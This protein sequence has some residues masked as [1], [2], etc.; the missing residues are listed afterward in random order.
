M[1]TK[2]ESFEIQEYGDQNETYETA[3]LLKQIVQDYRNENNVVSHGFKVDF[4]GNMMKVIMSFYE[5]G[6]PAKRQEISDKVNEYHKQIFSMLKKE[7][8]KRAKRELAVTEQKDMADY[9]VAKVSL[10]DRYMLTSWR[11]YTLDS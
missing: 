3:Q 6:Y 4:T 7:F 9:T 2:P 11:C 8:K 5:I 10:N 1:N